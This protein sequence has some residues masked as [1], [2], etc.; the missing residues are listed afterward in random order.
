M[1]N[2]ESLFISVQQTI[3]MFLLMCKG[4]YGSL[5]IREDPAGFLRVQNFKSTLIKSVLLR[6]RIAGS[7]SINKADC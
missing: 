6:W 3:N 4:I 7:L 2:G 5:G 1:P